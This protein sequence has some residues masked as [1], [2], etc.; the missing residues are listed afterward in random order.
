MTG[1]NP[2]ER[3]N[4]FVTTPRPP[5]ILFRGDGVYPYMTRLRIVAV[6]LA[7]TVTGLLVMARGVALKRAVSPP[8][9]SGGVTVVPS[10]P[11]SNNDEY[12]YPRGS[13]SPG[14]EG[15]DADARAWFSHLLRAAGAAPLWCGDDGR[16][17]AY[18]FMLV[19]GWGKTKVITARRSDG[20]WVLDA[21]EFQ[22]RAVARY[23]V[24]RRLSRPM[25][26][27]EVDSL[28][29]AL[30]IDGFWRLRSHERTRDCCYDGPGWFIEGRSE[31][32]YHAAYRAWDRKEFIR[33]ARLLMQFARM[34]GEE[35][36]APPGQQ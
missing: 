34:T 6:T 30:E 26:S 12:F 28:T 15:A 31:G 13:L 3:P 8:E 36:T 19:F 11:P 29:S 9:I 35:N 20:A 2:V 1:S 10:C 5:G 21:V 24:D 32:G 14:N 23:T 22:H 27:E 4:P 16:G 25:S 18:R 7:V 33:T 17:V